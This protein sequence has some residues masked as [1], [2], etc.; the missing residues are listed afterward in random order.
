MSSPLPAYNAMVAS[1]A[2]LPAQRRLTPAYVSW[3]EQAWGYYDELGEFESAVSWAANTMS[4]VRLIAAKI[5]PGGGEPEP[6]AKG[7]AAEAV[8]RLAG[9][10]GGQSQMMAELTAHLKV[11][12]ECWLVGE[13]DPDSKGD[14][15][16]SVRSA[17]ELRV[18]STG[19][20]QLRDDPRSTAWR[21][22]G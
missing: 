1:A 8:G 12:G 15:L 2:V 19:G 17:D 18:T 4:R 3:Q 13:D 20:W 11:V 16:W 10:P 7:L 5:T 9:G 21:A 14:E 22:G 6:V